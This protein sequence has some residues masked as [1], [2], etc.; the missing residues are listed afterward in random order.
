M[1]TKKATCTSD[2]ILTYTCESCNETKTEVIEATGHEYKFG[3]CINCGEKQYLGS[4]LIPSLKPWIDKL[5]SD[6][7]NWFGSLWR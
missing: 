5:I 7:K 4:N 2:G 6:L 3:R 1:V